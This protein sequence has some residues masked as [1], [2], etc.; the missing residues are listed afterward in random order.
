MFTPVILG[1]NKTT[2]SIANGQNDFYPLYASLGNP[3]N[4]V[5]R[6]HRNAVALIGFLTIPKSTFQ[7]PLNL[8]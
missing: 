3:H 7:S 5:R 2:V 6:A 8:F 1:S 4:S